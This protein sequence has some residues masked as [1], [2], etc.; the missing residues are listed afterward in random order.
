MESLFGIDSKLNAGKNE[1]LWEPCSNKLPPAGIS[2]TLKQ[3][4]IKALFK[5]KNS[6]YTFPF[7]KYFADDIVFK[8]TARG[9]QLN[10]YRKELFPDSGAGLL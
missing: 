8:S 6:K 4:K 1:T 10:L 9:L 5:N 2:M 7:F 3:K